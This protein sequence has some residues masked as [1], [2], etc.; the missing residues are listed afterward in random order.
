[1]QG[2]IDSTQILIHRARNIL[3]GQSWAPRLLLQSEGGS[4]SLKPHWLRMG[5]SC[6][7]GEL[8][9]NLEST[10]DKENV[11][12]INVR[13][14]LPFYGVNT[15]LVGMGNRPSLTQSYLHLSPNPPLHNTSS[16][17][18]SFFIWISYGG[19]VCAR[20]CVYVHVHG[21][22]AFVHTRIHTEPSTFAHA[23]PMAIPRPLH[24]GY[25]PS[26]SEIQCRGISHP[27]AFSDTLQA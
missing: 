12:T 23:A 22:H 9:D 21:S 14:T 5:R 8:R 26:P 27:K 11:K 3:T 15:F 16:T 13:N 17:P 19:C 20:A 25:S 6:F 4:T 2:L 18:N 7:P 10:G 24:L 1:M